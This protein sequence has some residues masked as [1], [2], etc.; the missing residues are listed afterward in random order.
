MG[1]LFLRSIKAGIAYFSLA[2]GA[3]FAMGAIR[4]PFLV[5]RLGER[6]AELIEMPFMLI[7]I[8]WAARF[9]TIRFALPATVLVRLSTGV[10]ALGLLI[11][12]ELLLAVAF[13]DQSLGQYVSSRDP[14][15]GTVYLAM[16]F[17]FAAMP[18][19]ITRLRFG[20][21]HA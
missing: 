3:G 17:L 7:V 21:D 20:R 12:T 9:I 2:F 13:Q 1:T 16:L 18:L 4:V 15:S 8:I 19:V 10:L 6:V 14:V 5:P 11:A